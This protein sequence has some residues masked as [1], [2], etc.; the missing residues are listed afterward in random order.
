MQLEKEKKNEVDNEIKVFT[1]VDEVIKLNTNTKINSD[2]SPSN[3]V[4]F[5]SDKSNY[6]SFNLT[7]ESFFLE[8]DQIRNSFDFIKGENLIDYDEAF[9]KNED[10]SLMGV[11]VMTEFRLLF[12]FK[13][14]SLMEKLNLEEDYF[15]LPLY[16]IGKVEKSNDK[17]QMTKY[18]LDL[19]LKDSSRI[20]KFIVSSSQ[21]KFFANLNT[22]V[23]PKDPEMHYSF[24][25]IYRAGL[26][27]DL[28]EGL[29]IEGW[30]IYNPEK[31]YAR[32][33]INFLDDNYLLKITDL[34]KNFN[35]CPT[36]PE[37]LI[38]PRG[39]SDEEI[40]EASNFRTKNRFPILSYVYTNIGNRN[41]YCYASIW[42]SSQTKSGI[43]GNKRSSEDEKLLR[44]ICDL[45][46]K[47]VIYDARP[48]INAL[49]NRV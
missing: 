26:Q 31:E 37:I 49:A 21:L 36:Y 4:E 48:Y 15:K 42:R 47:L 17:K 13:D 3:N 45:N 2:T 9:Y 28:N 46:N 7:K 19:T 10:I 12:K 22:R 11:L 44:A 29:L 43:T 32:Q 25:K 41:R 5:K 38:V 27:Q 40:R 6:P 14:E 34:N 24:A 30:D 33:G 23:F 20:Y 18:N 39:I 35:L 8:R 1:S 16:M